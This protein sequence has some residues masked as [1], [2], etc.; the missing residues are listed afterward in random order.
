M[1]PLWTRVKAARAEDG[2]VHCAARWGSKNC[3][4]CDRLLSN[5][6]RCSG[7]KSDRAR[8]SS[9]IF[10]SS[11][12]AWCARTNALIM[13]LALTW[14]GSMVVIL[15]SGN[16]KAALRPR[17]WQPLIISR[18]FDYVKYNC[19]GSAMC[20]RRWLPVR[21]LVADDLAFAGSCRRRRLPIECYVNYGRNLRK[22]P[23]GL[24]PLHPLHPAATSPASLGDGRCAL[25][26]QPQNRNAAW[27]ASSA[28]SSR[29]SGSET[30]GDERTK[31]GSV[32]GR[33]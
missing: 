23:L 8:K 6:T 30:W 17:R 27:A 19:A 10:G 25:G 15:L 11:C 14:F 20:L 33:R 1:G 29:L 7:E 4:A 31:A 2:S 21:S 16:G 3:S 9:K 5:C 28:P 26:Q 22:L 18:I 12:V 24:H 13:A 32:R